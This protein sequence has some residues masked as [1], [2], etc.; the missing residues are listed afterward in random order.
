M[1]R[2][3]RLPRPTLLP[4]RPLGNVF[5]R[6]AVAVAF[7]LSLC[8]PDARGQY[9]H[10]DQAALAD[11]VNNQI[12]PIEN[13]PP[14]VT[15]RYFVAPDSTIIWNKVL[16]YRRIGGKENKSLIQILNRDQPLDYLEQGDTLVLP[17]RLDLDLRAYSPYPREYEGARDIDKVLI[18]DKNLQAFAAYEF[19]KLVRWGP[20]NTGGA[21]TETPSGRFNYN[22]KSEYRVSSL[23]P[24]GD[25]WEMYWVFNF[26]EARGIHTHQY[27]MPTGAASSHGCV[28]M[29]NADARWVYDWA[30]EYKKQG[31]RI[32]EQ[33]TMVLVIGDA[34]HD[35]HPTFFVDTPEGPILRE[36][37]LPSDP[38]A[39]EPGTPQQVM[40]DRL[41]K[42]NAP[43]SSSSPER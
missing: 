20:V 22:W 15:Y 39:V 36:A 40:F 13:V 17:S 23:S 34:K 10:F 38:W 28:R 42:R 32:V 33:G 31:N 7:A 27:Y 35:E 21:G 26:H 2:F 24:P 8:G 3:R 11:L 12:G 19:G 14:D 6:L 41:R 25:P 5:G 16:L 1:M 43:S 18:I 9:D 29:M 4:H 30:D 37:M